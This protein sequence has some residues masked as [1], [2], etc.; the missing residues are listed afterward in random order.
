[1]KLRKCKAMMK[2]Q[3]T[4]MGRIVREAT[5]MIGVQCVTMVVIRCIVVTDVRK[6]TIFSATFLPWPKSLPMIGSVTCVNH[7][8]RFLAIQPAKRFLIINSPSLINSCVFAFYSNFTIRWVFIGF[9]IFSTLHWRNFSIFQYPESVM[10]RDCSDLNFKEYLD[11]I[12]EPIA[13][14]VIKEKLDR[15]NPEMVRLFLKEK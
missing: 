12:K 10:F 14:D 4:L 7:R 6:F 11:I 1:M 13:L 9:L 15:E 5:I 3:K 2:L 8:M